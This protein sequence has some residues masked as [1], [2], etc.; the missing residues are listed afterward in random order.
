M[1]APEKFFA[2]FLDIFFPFFNNLN[3]FLSAVNHIRLPRD[4]FN[5]QFRN[6]SGTLA[7]Y[8]C[9][10]GQYVSTESTDV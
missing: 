8:A 2:G 7:L 3:K 1:E 5:K 9:R 4:R 10:Y 6:R